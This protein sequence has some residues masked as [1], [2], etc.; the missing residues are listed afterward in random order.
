MF[1]IHVHC[2]FGTTYT[3]CMKTWSIFRSRCVGFLCTRMVHG[4]VLCSGEIYFSETR[5]SRFGWIDQK[6]FWNI[7]GPSARLRGP[8]FGDSRKSVAHHCCTLVTLALL[9]TLSMLW[10]CWEEKHNSFVY[11][12]V[13]AFRALSLTFWHD[14]EWMCLKTFFCVI[15]YFLMY[16]RMFMY[17][18]NSSGQK[19]WQRQSFIFVGR[20]FSSFCIDSN[21]IFHVVHCTKVPLK[22][23]I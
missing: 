15:F 16:I 18:V 13:C 23:I 7:L 9:I 12:C 8:N 22:I 6:V 21:S 20:S 19:Q 1:Y 10:N 14:T 11:V 2:T 17:N 5:N 3:Q 4:E